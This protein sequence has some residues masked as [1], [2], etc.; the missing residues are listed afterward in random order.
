LPYVFLVFAFL[1]QWNFPS[2]AVSVFG[3]PALKT[4]TALIEGSALP[5]AKSF[6]GGH[7]VSRVM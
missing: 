3:A 2:D 1:V 4:E 6:F 7:H 5:K